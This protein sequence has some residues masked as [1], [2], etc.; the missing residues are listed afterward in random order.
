MAS[1]TDRVVGFAV[2]VHGP[3]AR[4]DAIAVTAEH[5]GTGVGRQLLAGAERVAKRNG[6]ARM[7]LATAETNL[8][9]LDLFLR[10]GYRIT[11]R[12]PRYYSRGQDALEM[13]KKL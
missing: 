6:A 5:R 13:S 10:S 4:L 2:V 3:T 11:R 1:V 12:L 7:T 8:A 9:A